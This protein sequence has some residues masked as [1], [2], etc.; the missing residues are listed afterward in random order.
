MGKGQGAECSEAV[1]VGGA[2]GLACMG[3]DAVGT[4][5]VGER[6]KVVGEG[7][8]RHPNAQHACQPA[9]WLVSGDPWPEVGGRRPQSAV[10]SRRRGDRWWVGLG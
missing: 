9:G 5:M 10:G 7:H 1:F 4:R 8:Q 3:W 6:Q 2:G